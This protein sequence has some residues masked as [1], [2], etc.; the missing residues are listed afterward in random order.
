[1]TSYA[2]GSVLF[3]DGMALEDYLDAVDLREVVL[4]APARR[5]QWVDE[6]RA[7]ADMQ[8]LEGFI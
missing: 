2:T 7:A 4:P 8:S 5:S 1:V 6:F 3:H